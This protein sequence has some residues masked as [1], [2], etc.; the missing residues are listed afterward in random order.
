MLE[1]L[2]GEIRSIEAQIV[3]FAG[4]LEGKAQAIKDGEAQA[5]AWYK[6]HEGEIRM[7]CSFAE[8][9]P[10]LSAPAEACIAIMDEIDAFTK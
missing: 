5:V 7:A 3:A 2:I 4:S 10:Y 1:K 6:A 8:H 9:F